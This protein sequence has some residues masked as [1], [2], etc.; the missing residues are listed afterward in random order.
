[1]RGLL[2]S[3]V[4]SCVVVLALV[5]LSDTQQVTCY[6]CWYS[7]IPIS[8]GGQAYC[9]DPFNSNGVATCT[10]ASCALGKYLIKS[11]QYQGTY[12]IYRSC[13]QQR[14]SQ[15]TNFRAKLERDVIEGMA[16]GRECLCTSSRCNDDCFC[17][18][19]SY[20]P[21]NSRSG[22]QLSLKSL[23]PLNGGTMRNTSDTSQHLFK[24]SQ[25]SR[26]GLLST[27]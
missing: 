23:L 22:G 20:C 13:Y 7:N 4:T 10:G 15:C 1:M 6:E 5:S 21:D 24:Q 26:F 16:E 8:S 11:G 27:F 12:E 25:F 17:S 19:T 14:T 9:R 3:F 2:K 18:D